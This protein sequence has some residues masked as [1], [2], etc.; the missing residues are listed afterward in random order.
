MHQTTAGFDTNYGTKIKSVSLKIKYRLHNYVNKQGYSQ[1]YLHVSGFGERLRKPIAIECRPDDWDNDTNRII[2]KAYNAA[3]FNLMI[4]NYDAK[5]TRIKTNYRL[6]NLILTPKRL[7]HEL[8]SGTSRVDFI[9]YM[10]RRITKEA[11]GMTEGYLKRCRKV[12]SKLS[13]YKSTLFFAEINYKFFDDYRN[14]CLS[15]GNAKTTIAGNIAIIKKFLKQASKENIKLQVNLDDIKRGSMK[16]N[17]IDLHP[18]E[19]QKYYNY[20]FSEFISEDWK[21]VLGYFL[22]ACFTSLRWQQV[23]D[24]DRG[25]ILD[26]TFVNFYVAKTGKRHSI[27]L[28]KR[29]KAIT[30]HC[31]ELFTTKISS[32]HVNRE[33][34]K[35]SKLMG[36]QRNITFHIS[37]HTFATNFLRAGGD[38][39]ELQNIMDHED[40]KTTMIYVH[41]VDKEAH[42]S[43]AL[44]DN[45]F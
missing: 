37:R 3:D 20:Y 9:K 28:N 36:I 11:P 19:L 8:N 16:G 24:L 12:L 44:M 5:I 10:E 13:K 33:L 32:Q 6:S 39:R 34:K 4:E 21:L 2:K 42:D 38:I 26:S 31:Q 18:K 27:A 7:L 40:I 23:I 1:L 45:L 17:R 15:I 41:I 43:M 29:S 22:F 30:K 14:Y 25:S 35:I